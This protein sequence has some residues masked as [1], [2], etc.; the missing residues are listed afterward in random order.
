MP[1]SLTSP[2]PSVRASAS[3]SPDM[4]RSPP[5]V[6]FAL[7]VSSFGVLFRRI[8]ADACAELVCDSLASAAFCLFPRSIFTC[9]HKQIP[10]YHLVFFLW[11][12]LLAASRYSPSD[13][14][15]EG[16]ATARHTAQYRYALTQIETA[17][18]YRLSRRGTGASRIDNSTRDEPICQASFGTKTSNAHSFSRAVAVSSTVKKLSIGP[19]TRIHSSSTS[20]ETCVRLRISLGPTCSSTGVR[21]GRISRIDQYYQLDDLRSV[22]GPYAK[23][24]AHPRSTSTSA[25]TFCRVLPR[26]L[27]LRGR[28]ERD[29]LG[30]EARFDPAPA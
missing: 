26:S 3:R 16:Q 22:R 4:M 27:G 8:R 24:E 25:S 12:Q 7:P 2:P 21:Q 6:P 20:S 14:I 10:I 29:T 13:A 18:T 30:E 15:K 28:V 19:W 9:A 11:I 17:Y 23:S 1:S 5:P